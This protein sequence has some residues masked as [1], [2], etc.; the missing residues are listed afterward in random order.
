ML[1][2]PEALRQQPL[3]VE[4]IAGGQRQILSS[5]THALDIRLSPS[6]GQLLVLHAATGK[7]LS[8]TYVKVY[9]ED[10]AG[11]IAFYKDGYTDLRGRFDY[12]SLGT[13]AA[14]RIKRLAIFISH[15]QAGSTVREVSPP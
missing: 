10:Q 5:F 11:H 4:I 3:S 8:T 1:T 13:G 15:Q 6:S 12:A 2:V 14:H 9:A 7:A